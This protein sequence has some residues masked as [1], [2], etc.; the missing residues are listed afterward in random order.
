MKA[1]HVGIALSIVV[2][3]AIA[4]YFLFFWQPYTH[5]HADFAV[6]VHGKQ[7][8]FAQEKYMVPEEFCG[9]P[10]PNIP[11]SIV[12]LH[13]GLGSAVHVHLSGVTW[14]QFFQSLNMDFNSQCLQLDGNAYCVDDANT[15][16]MYVNGKPV[17]LY[18]NTPIRDL[19]Q[20]LISYG[21]K[22]RNVSSELGSI[23]NLARLQNKGESCDQ[24]GVAKKT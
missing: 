2:V 6:F 24:E 20:V 23:S 15:L 12:H 7:F 17:S 16:L 5:E 14:K 18:E 10:N 1:L 21:E 11:K 13:D 3:G 8:D 19:D 22:K 9:N 4:G